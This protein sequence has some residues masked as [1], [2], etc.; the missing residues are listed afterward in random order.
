[1]LESI[2]WRDLPL[3]SGNRLFLDYVE[4]DPRAL[5]FYTHA[6]TAFA[7]ALAARRTFSYPRAAVGDLL[8]RYNRPLGASEHTLAN[9]RALGEPDGYCV[10]GGQQAGFLGGPAYVAFKIACTIQ[11]A[12]R[13]AIELG[14]KVIPVFWLASEDHDFGEINHTHYVQADGEIGRVSFD[15]REKGRPIAD[16]PLGAEVHTALEAYWSSLQPGPYSDAVRAATTPRHDRYCDWIASMWL[17]LYADDGLVVVE[18][19][20]IRPV[21]GDLFG[22]M[23]RQQE[24]IHE[25]MQAIAQDL[26]SAGYTPLL[27]PDSA[28]VMYT[29][30]SNGQRVR[31][32]DAAAAAAEAEAHPERFSTDA[33]L[34]PL[35]ADSVLPVLASTL[36]AGELAYQGMLKPLY[37]LFGIP[38]PICLPRK[39]YTLVSGQQRE[40]LDAYGL[41]P[42]DVLTAEVEID[43]VMRRLMPAEDISR[44]GDARAGVAQALE[45][46][47]A[48][49]EAL[50]PNMSRSWE[51]AL[52][53]ALRNIDKLEERAVNVTL[54]RSGFARRE[55]QALRNVL[56]PRGRMQ[57]RVFPITHFMQQYG[58]T[59]LSRMTE[60]GDVA[61]FSHDIVT[62]EAED[63]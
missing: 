7:G 28:G 55:V 59:L 26:E 37:E 42:R 18:P 48:Y 32:Q 51:Q 40:R 35:F 45:P 61:R 53:T 3:M 44:F 36:G 4:S 29:F 52:N 46:L 19:N 41:T 20:T 25:R 43:Q 50:D 9:I 15:W 57:E 47:K 49:I 63:A 54:S 6:P 31:V 34:R 33:A 12:R 14:A 21:A 39:S 62:V 1:M 38:Q 8:E 17:Q 5:S 11:L 2:D 16:M 58:P 23:L 30:G 24:P 13:L 27:S 56:L 60:M 22:S 10:V